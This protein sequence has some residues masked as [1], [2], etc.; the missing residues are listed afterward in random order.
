MFVSL[1]MD[2]SVFAVCLP[3]AAWISQ[4]DTTKARID[5]FPD[6]LHYRLT[7]GALF[8]AT[9]ILAMGVHVRVTRNM[10]LT[11]YILKDILFRVLTAQAVTPRAASRP[12]LL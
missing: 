11:V 2:N 1:D 10:S 7:T 9:S 6:R 8:M 3:F 4:R 5:N 12:L